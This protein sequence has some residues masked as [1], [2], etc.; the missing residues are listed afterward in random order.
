MATIPPINR[1]RIIMDLVKDSEVTTL[2][3]YADTAVDYLDGAT[4]IKYANA[5]IS[6]YGN[7]SDE[8]LSEMTNEDK[9]LLYIDILRMFHKR[10]LKAA[11]VPGAVDTAREVEELAAATEGQTDFGDDEYVAPEPDPDDI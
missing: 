7:V 3:N 4:A 2:A 6:V 5:A 8:V 10:I 1:A 9:A 11:N